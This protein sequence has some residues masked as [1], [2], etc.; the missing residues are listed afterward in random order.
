[1]SCCSSVQAAEN[2]GT[3]GKWSRFTFWVH[4]RLVEPLGQLQASL[5]PLGIATILARGEQ[6][7]RL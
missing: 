7:S 5:V 6:E 4:Y 1:M 3:G 2:G